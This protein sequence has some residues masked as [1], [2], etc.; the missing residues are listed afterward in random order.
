MSEGNVKTGREQDVILLFSERRIADVD[1]A[2]GILPTEP[3]ADLGHR[4]EI[5]RTSIIA[6]VSQVRVKVQALR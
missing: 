5:K 1:I 4:A 2:E 3:L 6:G